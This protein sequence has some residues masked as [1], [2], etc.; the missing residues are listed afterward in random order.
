VTAQHV[1]D[2]LIDEG[3]MVD[4]N[5]IRVDL[6][7]AARSADFMT[8]ILKIGHVSLEKAAPGILD[9]VD[10]SA[11]PKTLLITTAYALD[12][13]PRIEGADRVIDANGVIAHAEYMTRRFLDPKIDPDLIRAIG[14]LA[15][16]RVNQLEDPVHGRLPE[17]GDER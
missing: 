7:S 12:V 15:Q 9:W 14:V 17:G 1:L 16:M 6:F 10:M 8:A 13:S 11:L 5:G 2:L 3:G 4:Y